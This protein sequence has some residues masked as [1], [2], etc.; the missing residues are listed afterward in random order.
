MLFLD[1]ALQDVLVSQLDELSNGLFVVYLVRPEFDMPAQ[2]SGS[3]QYSGWVRQGCPI[4]ETDVYMCT[5]DIDIGEWSIIHT[6]HRIIIMKDT[7]NIRSAVM[8]HLNPFAGD[9][10]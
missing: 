6:A 7:L 2:F 3:F 10:S 5:V 4:K 9:R 8:D 1:C